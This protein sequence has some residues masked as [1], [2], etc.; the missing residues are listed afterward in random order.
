MKYNVQLAKKKKE[1]EIITANEP[2]RIVIDIDEDL[3]T[4]K[5]VVNKEFA[6]IMR[7]YLGYSIDFENDLCKVKIKIKHGSNRST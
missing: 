6:E 7:L 3:Y 4:T 2:Y 1:N 5:M